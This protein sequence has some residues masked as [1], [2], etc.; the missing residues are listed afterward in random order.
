MPILCFW[1]ENFI[2]FNPVKQNWWN[3]P[4]GFC[5]TY[6]KV[7]HFVQMQ[8]CCYTRSACYNNVAMYLVTFCASFQFIASATISNAIW[9]QLITH[10][11]VSNDFAKILKR[12]RT[13]RELECLEIWSYYNFRCG[14]LDMPDADINLMAWKVSIN[15]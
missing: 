7:T 13:R 5:R 10:S 9:F 4:E 2:T 3:I 1:S 11:P 12:Q 6:N 8:H 15:K 14:S